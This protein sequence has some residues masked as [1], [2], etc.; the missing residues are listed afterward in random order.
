MSETGGKDRVIRKEDGFYHWS[1]GIDP[2]YYRKT[3]MPGVWACAGIAVFLFLFGVI[4][5]IQMDDWETF[6]II[7]LCVA[8]FFVIAGVVFG[9]AFFLAKDPRESYLMT[10]EY[11]KSGYGKSSVYFS[12][13]HIKVLTLTD[14]YI[15]LAGKVKQMRIYVPT[16]DMELVRS[17]IMNALPGDADIRYR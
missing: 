8:V 3:L 10:D 16:E 17:H 2:V 9:L 6:W 14:S 13:R 11:V 15:E 1:C 4:M 7:A 5:T 12:F